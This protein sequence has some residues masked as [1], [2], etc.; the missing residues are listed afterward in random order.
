MKRTRSRSI[1][2]NLQQKPSAPIRKT[3]AQVKAE[4]A[5]RKPKAPTPQKAPSAVQQEQQ[6]AKASKKNPSNPPSGT[7]TPTKEKSPESGGD[8]DGNESTASGKK[9]ITSEEEAKARLAEKRREMKEKMEREAE[10]ERKR[11]VLPYIVFCL[12]SLR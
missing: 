1:D 3:P 7:S 5:A 11:W 8:S 2:K 6:P 9:I 10:L 12:L 4:S